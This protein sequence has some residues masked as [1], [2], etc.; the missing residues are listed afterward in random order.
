M[1]RNPQRIQ[2]PSEQALSE[3]SL[4]RL[5]GPVVVSHRLC[6]T[7]HQRRRASGLELG[8]CAGRLR[9]RDIALWLA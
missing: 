8:S 2:K 1:S 9:R 4:Q 7:P 3:V 6:A 5:A